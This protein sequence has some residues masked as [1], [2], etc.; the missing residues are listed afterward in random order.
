MW[1]QKNGDS[2]VIVVRRLKWRLGKRMGEKTIR[3]DVIKIFAANLFSQ[4]LLLIV[5]GTFW[6]DWFYYYRDRTGLWK[7]FM[8]AGR[9]SSAYWVEAVWNIPHY[10]Y[11][12]LV[13]LL[14]MFTALIVYAILRNS[15]MFSIEE[16]RG[17]SILYSV[18]PIND[19]RI[20]LCTFSYAV[21]LASFLGGA[22]ILQKYMRGEKNHRLCFRIAALLLLGYSFIIQSLLIFY[23]AVLFYIFCCEYQNRG[24]ISETVKAMVR[25][26]G[27]FILPILFWVG[28][29][30]LFPAY[31]AF[32]NYN[33]VTIGAVAKA[34]C[35]LPLATI[36]QIQRNWFGIFD[37]VVSGNSIMIA[38][39]FIAIYAAIRMG[40]WLKEK[41]N[42]GI[43]IR[44][45]VS[46]CG[47]GGGRIL[48]SRNYS[49]VFSCLC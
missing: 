14:F 48:T 3:G 46:V 15:D 13:F 43:D 23:V 30:M 2:V 29:Q 18:I 1:L 20:I 17:L 24:K 36:K 42:Q 31:G 32:A 27:F 19:A 8:E 11:R 35:R 9:P 6:D 44:L 45:C 33:K 16:A 39:I 21:G 26:I 41:I 34:V 37:F 49:W 25:Y 12:W 10:G 22:Y 40:I 47:G 28:K 7:E 4:G 38:T 5:T